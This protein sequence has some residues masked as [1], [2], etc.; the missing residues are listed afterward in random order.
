MLE[1]IEFLGWVVAAVIAG[2]WI[3]I[4]IKKRKQRK[5]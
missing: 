2:A 3:F 1:K 5:G 4:I